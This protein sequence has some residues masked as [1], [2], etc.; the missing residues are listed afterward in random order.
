MRRT[1]SPIAVELGAVAFHEFEARRRGK[2]EVA[3]FNLRAA[4][5]G[6]RSHR[7]NPSAVDGNLRAVIRVTGARPDR[8]PRD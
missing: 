1:T 3:H 2:E 5:C 4:I 8:Q 7:A 6:G